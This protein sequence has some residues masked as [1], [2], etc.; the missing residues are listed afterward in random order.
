[1][2]SQ[3]KK[4]ILLGLC[5]CLLLGGCR[6]GGGAGTETDGTNVSHETENADM[7]NTDTMVDTRDETETEPDDGSYIPDARCVDFS[8]FDSKIL[9]AAF[10]DSVDTKLS[11]CQDGVCMTATARSNDPQVTFNFSD[12]FRAAGYEKA[13]TGG[14]V[15]FT[16]EE[17]TAMV[18][19]VKGNTGGLLE[20]FYATG[21]VVTATAECSVTGSYTGGDDWWYIML[22]FSRQR[23]KQYEGI[24]NNRC[25]IDWSNSTDK[26]D[27]LIL[28]E[29]RF[30]ATRQEAKVYADSRNKGVMGE[31]GY[32]DEKPAEGLE[33]GYYVCLYQ[34]KL[35]SDAAGVRG[36]FGTDALADARALCDEKKQLGYR[37]SD[38]KGN[39]IYAPYPLLQCDILREAK[40]VTDYVRRNHF[41]YGD[42]PINP[43]I[44]CRA[45]KVSCD[46][47]VCWVM[48]RVG[49]TDQ[50]FTQG[51]VVSA[52]HTWSQE[53][54]F[55]EITDKTQ[56]Q[57]GDI[58]LVRPNSSGTYALHTFLYAG[59][60]ERRRQFY[61]Y[62]CGS[63]ARINSVQPSSEA[64]ELQD[65]PF[66]R[67]YR[68][69]ATA[70][71]NVY[72]HQYYAGDSD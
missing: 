57:P 35:G 11:L 8:R 24:F 20:F 68:P 28:S 40:Y 30:F 26:G 41:T 25:R 70:E 52:M 37:V 54:G 50:P 63:D 51:V 19:K 72:Y 4:I 10:P 58:I 36:G 17:I 32:G 13:E 38:E 27:C 39:V 18:L 12:M 48:Y 59:Q 71:N 9:K 62:D 55:I 45:K 61:R 15:P 6:T 33:A 29:M 43:A 53:N 64:L 31:T 67:A 66:W 21:S 65:A 2:P 23:N 60:T 47:L 1:M 7:T 49:F 16:T 34:N 46:R 14:Y 5:A 42:A 44:N 3:K 69:V 56:L 22:D